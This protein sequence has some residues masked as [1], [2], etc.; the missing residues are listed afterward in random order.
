[1]V[2]EG[3]QRIARVQVALMV[4]QVFVRE[5]NLGD[6]QALFGEQFCIIGHQPRLPD[7]GAGLEFGQFV[8][9]FS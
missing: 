2:Q 4:L 7:G 5:Q 8:G 3:D 6:M 1:M 9:R